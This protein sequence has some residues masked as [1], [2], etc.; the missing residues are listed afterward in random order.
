MKSTERMALLYG[1]AFVGA[2]GVSMYRGRQGQE[3]L[4][5]TVL[6]GF[7]AGTAFNIVALRSRSLHSAIPSARSRPS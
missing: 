3:V 2:A 7:V 4:V 1:V 5:D 6:H